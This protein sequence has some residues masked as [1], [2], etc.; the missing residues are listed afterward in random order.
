MHSTYPACCTVIPQSPSSP[1]A[2]ILCHDHPTT[3]HP[4][5]VHPPTMN[6]GVSSSSS[7]LLSSDMGVVA[8]RAGEGSTLRKGDA[9]FSSVPPCPPACDAKYSILPSA[10]EHV[11]VTCRADSVQRPQWWV[12]YRWQRIES[13]KRAANCQLGEQ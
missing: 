8:G 10:R 7:R 2:T 5:R 6:M 4:P 1:T 13:E 3:T 12:V 11:S 9:S